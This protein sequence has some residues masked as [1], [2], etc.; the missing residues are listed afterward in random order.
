LCFGISTF[1]ACGNGTSTAVDGADAGPGGKRI[2]AGG[3][4]PTT[5]GDGSPGVDGG[6]TFSN[7]IPDFQHLEFATSAIAPGFYTF[8][9]SPNVDP[10]HPEAAGGRVGA[11]VGA[12]GIVV[13]DASY[14]AVS[15]KLFR[16][17][18]KL[19]SAPL[20]Y[21]IDTHS[22]ADHTGGN[23][24]FVKR[25]AVLVA[26]EEASVEVAAPLPAGLANTGIASD[27][28]DRVPTVTFGLT[29]PLTLRLD[30]EIIDLIPLPP[31]HTDG[32]SLI[33]FEHADVIM[34]GDFYRNY[35]YP[36]VDQQHGGS[37]QGVL[38]AL[39]LLASMAGAETVLVPGH[40]TLVHR[41][42]L[43]AYR[44]MITQVENAVSALIAE[45]KS[46]PD[47]LAAHV[48]APYDD[49]VSGALDPLPLGFGTSAD[50]F[51][52]EVYAELSAAP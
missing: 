9:G 28:P 40:G 22:H 31:A 1:V 27:D 45:G 23:A 49:V 42:A 10:G 24:N 37:F 38:A 8:T 36:F 25:G 32:D 6:N 43:G 20:R 11:L 35:G 21:L 7:A 13:V 50:R 12:D 39:D 4:D 46:L 44:D 17:I 33:R 52:S 41:D 3:S 30:D 51:V 18:D 2:E 47:V 34:I 5:S 19:G 48:T 15:D 14:A 16:A 29:T 26:R